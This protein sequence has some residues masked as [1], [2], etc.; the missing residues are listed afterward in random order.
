M[1]LAMPEARSAGKPA[2]R[3]RAS[4]RLRAAGS[5]HPESPL[6]TPRRSDCHSEQATGWL[7]I[8][9]CLH[10]TF[11]KVRFLSGAPRALPICPSFLC[12]SMVP[13]GPRPAPHL[14]HGV[15]QCPQFTHMISH[16]PRA[17][18][19]TCRPSPL[20]HRL[21]D[22]WASWLGPLRAGVPAL[23]LRTAPRCPLG[24]A[25]SLGLLASPR[26]GVLMVRV[27]PSRFHPEHKE[28]SEADLSAD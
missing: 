21:S 13:V 23:L 12:C 1:H 27:Q 16:G 7:K 20:A 10:L 6:W 2:P 8:L 24:L 3:S 17:C 4:S 9:W 22:C 14:A 19:P 18:P 5:V 15:R 11:K 25:P 28:P 26:A